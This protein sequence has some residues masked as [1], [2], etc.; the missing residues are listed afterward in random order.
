MED[1]MNQMHKDI[2]RVEGKLDQLRESISV[3]NKTVAAIAGHEARV[4]KLEEGHIQ[5]D[6]R[7]VKIETVCSARGIRLEK[8]EEHIRNDTPVEAWVNRTAAKILIAIGLY[9]AGVITSNL[10]R[11]FAFLG[12]VL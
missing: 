4:I 9:I 12:R 5:H 2:G 1:R 7:I 8:A 10:P 3:L 11:I 6:K